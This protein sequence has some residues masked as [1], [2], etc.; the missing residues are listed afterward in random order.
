VATESSKPE[1]VFP[2]IERVLER[3]FALL[4]LP[5]VLAIDVVRAPLHVLGFPFLN[6]LASGTS[7][8]LGVNL[9]LS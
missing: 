9:V 5:H 7:V 6:W 2:L 8:P 3:C 4:L 1:N